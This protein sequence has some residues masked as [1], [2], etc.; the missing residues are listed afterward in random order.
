MEHQ[1][2][3]RRQV[4]HVVGLEEWWRRLKGLETEPRFTV[5]WNKARRR[6]RITN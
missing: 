2:L 6:A 5:V 1:G 3:S 4:T